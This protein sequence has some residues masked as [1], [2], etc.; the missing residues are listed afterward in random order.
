MVASRSSG[1]IRCSSIIYNFGK[2]YNGDRNHFFFIVMEKENL[3]PKQREDLETLYKVSDQVTE[4]YGILSRIGEFYH[5]PKTN[6]AG[7]F[8]DCTDLTSN[9]YLLA[10]FIV[11]PSA[12]TLLPDIQRLHNA[13]FATMCT[14]LHESKHQDI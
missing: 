3:T 12:R 9:I 13:A 7:F 11:K 1:V 14:R 4:I 8:S 5:F 2:F 10:N 6:T